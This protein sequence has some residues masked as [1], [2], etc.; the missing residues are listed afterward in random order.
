MSARRR[1][2]RRD[3]TPAGR[4]ASTSRAADDWREDTL[5]H[6]REVI[7]RAD[8]TAV[9]EMKWKKPSNP[10]GVPVWSHG[11]ILCVA[12]RLKNAV[13]LTFP[14]GVQIPD[15]KKLFNTRLE[16]RTVRALDVHEGEAVEDGA[17][18]R[19]ILEAVRLNTSKVAARGS[20]RN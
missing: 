14:K 12:N 19:I 15:P 5:A 11:G 6:L 9:E 17:L 3:R 16:S 10:E 1:P 2:S 20:P 4:R 8:P 18:K 7:L 13:R